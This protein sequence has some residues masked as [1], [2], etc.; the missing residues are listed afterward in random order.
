MGKGKGS[1]HSLRVRVCVGSALVA[2]SA[3][4]TG[5][6]WLLHHRMQARCG[7]RLALVRPSLP[8]ARHYHAGVVGA[9]TVGGLRLRG[10]QN[11]WL[12]AQFQEL[13]YYIERLYRPGLA[14]YFLRIFW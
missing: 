5:L 12:T 2:F 8:A 14:R 4:R 11:H 9:P 10:V 6:A 13:R 3:L 7:F 1:R